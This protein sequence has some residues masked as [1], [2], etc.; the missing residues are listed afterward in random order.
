MGLGE[1]AREEVGWS[2]GARNPSGFRLS[3]PVGRSRLRPA[4]WTLICAVLGASP[5]P[6][7][8]VPVTGIRGFDLDFEALAEF[9]HEGGAH[10]PA[11]L[12]VTVTLSG[13]GA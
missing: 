4:P 11:P 5:Q 8:S 2:W 12:I 10:C 9:A 13:F 6:P 1:A 7:G 3:G